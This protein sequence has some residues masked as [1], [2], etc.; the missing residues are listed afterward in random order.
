MDTFGN[1]WANIIND[2]FSVHF[3]HPHLCVDSI[4][5][6]IVIQIYAKLFFYFFIMLVKD[7]S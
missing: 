2:I 6:L 5:V 3:V 7:V 1:K 4:L